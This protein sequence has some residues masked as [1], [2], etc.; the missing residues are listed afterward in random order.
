LKIAVCILL[1]VGILLQSFG[2]LVIV[3][4]YEINKDTIT[5]LFCINKEKPVL[6]CNGKCYLQRQLK[7][8]Q[9]NEQLPVSKMKEKQPVTQYY[10]TAG[11]WYASS[12]VNQKNQLPQLVTLPAREYY[13]SVFH[14]PCS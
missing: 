10:Q 12:L 3:I 11:W 14:P 4:G 8:E 1:S 6:H 13:S 9:K 2:S 7:E 5:K